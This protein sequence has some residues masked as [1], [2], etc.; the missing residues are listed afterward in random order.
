[1]KRKGR[2]SERIGFDALPAPLEKVSEYT[3]LHSRRVHVK[4]HVLTKA[5]LKGI[6]YLALR[7]SWNAAYRIGRLIGLL[8]YRFNVRRDVAMTNLDIVYGNSRNHQEKENLYRACLINFGLL[9]INHLRLPYLGESFWKKHCEWKNAHIFT[10]AAR[11]MK[12]VV[13]V[14]GHIGLMDLAGGK[15]GMSGYPVSAVARRIKNPAVD[16]FVVD[17][18][19]SMNFGTIRHRNSMKRILTGIKQGEAIVFVLDQNVKPTVGVFINWLGRIASTVHAGA[20]I[21]RKT[22][23]PVIAGY[24]YQ[25][26]PEKFELVFTEEVAWQPCPE[27]PKKEILLNTQNQA[28]AVQKIIYAHPELWFWIHRRWKTQPEGIPN[29][30]KEKQDH[31]QKS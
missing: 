10:E 11:R 1:M 16:E 4:G 26:G 2:P 19:N 7:L 3:R 22:G 14:S 23:A 5:F 28:N 18:R 30:Y 6:V 24:F 21:A 12:G 31:L 9:I 25:K 20:Y 13:L 8:F 15:L 29:P 27:D 17:A